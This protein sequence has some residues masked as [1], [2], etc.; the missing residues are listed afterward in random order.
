MPQAI[1]SEGLAQGPYMAARAG[2]EPTT[3]RMQDT[4]PSAEAPCPTNFRLCEY[5]FSCMQYN[6][7]CLFETFHAFSLP[8]AAMSL[9]IDL[10]LWCFLI[11]ILLVVCSEY[12]LLH[13]TPTKTSS[14]Q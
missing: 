5:S 11:V 14:L 13:L 7:A 1:V 4:E 10:E 2:F 6:C 3:L 8:R 9:D 12:Q